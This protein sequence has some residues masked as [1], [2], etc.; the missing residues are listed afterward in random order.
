MFVLHFSNKKLCLHTQR[1][2][3]YCD[4]PYTRCLTSVVPTLIMHIAT[5][6]S[7][8]N[9]GLQQFVQIYCNQLQ[10]NLTHLAKATIVTSL[11]MQVRLCYGV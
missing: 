2:L 6:C 10:S 1:C 5:C 3:Y 11:C 7:S 8:R 9:L 4:R